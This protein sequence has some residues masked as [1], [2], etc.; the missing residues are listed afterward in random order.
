[1]FELSI[2]RFREQLPIAPGYAKDHVDANQ[3][4]RVTRET[5][6]EVEESLQVPA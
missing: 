5:F 3:H 2:V 6:G 1:M 4:W